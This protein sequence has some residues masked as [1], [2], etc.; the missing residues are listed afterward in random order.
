MQKNG[1]TCQFERRGMQLKVTVILFA[2]VAFLLSLCACSSKKSP[3]TDETFLTAIEASVLDR[4]GSSATSDNDYVMAVNRELAYLQDYTSA[5]FS[6]EQLG[7]IAEKYLK[8]LGLQK[9][10]LSMMHAW[11]SQIGWQEGFVYRM[12][13]LNDLYE[14]YGFLADN[15]DFVATYILAYDQEA[16][17]LRAYYSLED[18]IGSQMGSDDFS[19]YWSDHDCCFDFWNNTAYQFSAVFEIK[20][21]DRNKNL[22]KQTEVPVE[23]IRPDTGYTISIY[24]EKPWEAG[25]WEINN[26]YTDVV[27]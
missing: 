10:S 16:A 27:C 11:E 15:K 20:I 12:E 18:D 4:M 3:T 13:A 17:R 23:N 14:E 9:E 22:I 8:G 6:D 5:E 24:K 7:E 2:C 19:A 25:T 1:F 26:Y 21:F